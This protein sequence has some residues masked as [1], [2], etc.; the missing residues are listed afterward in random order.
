MGKKPQ[1]T[2]K[3]YLEA[4]DRLQRLKVVLRQRD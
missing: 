4:F 1:N 2:D 3:L